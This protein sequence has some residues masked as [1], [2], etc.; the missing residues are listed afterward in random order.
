MLVGIVRNAAETTS[1]Q[2]GAVRV[3][4]ELKGRE[5]QLVVQGGRPI[6]DLAKVRGVAEN[7]FNGTVNVESP[8][9]NTTTLTITL[10]LPPQREGDRGRS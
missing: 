10:P 6:A 7:G 3:Q 2:P 1:G 9:G 8:S 4:L 5:L